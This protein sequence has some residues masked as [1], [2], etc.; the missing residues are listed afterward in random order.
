VRQG[1]RFLKLSRDEK[2]LTLS[3]TCNANGH[4]ICLLVDTGAGRTNISEEIAKRIGVTLTGSAQTGAAGSQ[5]VAVKTGRIDAL[6]VGDL[7]AHPIDVFVVDDSL[8]ASAKQL[9]STI[10]DGILAADWL[11]QH[12]CVLDFAN[13]I[14]YYRDESKLPAPKQSA[15]RSPLGVL[16]AGNGYGLIALTPQKQSGELLV[17]CKA[18]GIQIKLL[19][20]TGG[21]ATAISDETAIE[22]KLS[23]S[24][25]PIRLAMI[26]GE[27]PN[28][29]QARIQS[30][31]IGDSGQGASEV[32]VI[33]LRAQRRQAKQEG[34][35]VLDGLL[36]SVWLYY[37]SAVIDFAHDE[38]Y[39]F[40]P[41]K[42]HV[43]LFSGQWKATRVIVHGAAE[44][45]DRARAW[46]MTIDESGLQ[47]QDL[48]SVRS[49]DYTVSLGWPHCPINLLT[50]PSP[51]A[52]DRKALFGICKVAETGNTL[53]L[54]FSEGENE[55]SR[56]TEFVSTKGSK[57][58]LVEF[59]RVP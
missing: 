59:E 20:D 1:Y 12:H 50:R 53:M 15:D 21:P 32:L 56:P 48:H 7:P 52:K 22:L 34:K 47:L 9:G 33:N 26:G 28:V 39:W 30:F 58:I 11:S 42:R 5:L 38:I 13:R 55:T 6:K 41:A 14:L 43:A 24:P 23:T 46:R 4:Q 29:R 36:G 54:C 37:Y 25:T 3:A 2:S 16:L 35:V 44:S 51:D 40:P 49:Y 18:N 45:P 57:V 27:V 31:E 17:S 10:Y 19:V 8:R